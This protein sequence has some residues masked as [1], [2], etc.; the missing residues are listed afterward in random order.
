MYATTE[1]LEFLEDQGIRPGIVSGAV[2]CSKITESL[3]KQFSNITWVSAQKRGTELSLTIREGIP[4]EKTQEAAGACDLEA[5]EA[6]TIV[7]MVTRSGYPKAV[8][9][10]PCE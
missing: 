5:E 6:G 7:K 8:P 10:D 1:L 4:E 9:G 2:N 3:R